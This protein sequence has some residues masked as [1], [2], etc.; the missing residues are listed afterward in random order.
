MR[1]TLSQRVYG[2][3]LGSRNSC[4]IAIQSHRHEPNCSGIAQSF[5]YKDP[6]RPRRP[7]QWGGV[8]Y[9]G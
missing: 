7:V 6:V 3:T 2:L 9:A 5:I 4:S 1:D 8:N